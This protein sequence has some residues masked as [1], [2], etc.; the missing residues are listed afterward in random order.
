MEIAVL[1]FCIVRC[2]L[3]HFS[4]F[5]D[6]A[7]SSQCGVSNFV[8]YVGY[9]S[10]SWGF[11]VVEGVD[12]S[13]RSIR[14]MELVQQRRDVAE[15]WHVMRSRRR[16]VSRCRSPAT[17]REDTRD[18]TGEP[19]DRP[20]GQLTE[21]RVTRWQGLRDVHETSS[22]CI[23]HRDVFETSPHIFDVCSEVSRTTEAG[24]IWSE[25]TQ[26]GSWRRQRL[27]VLYT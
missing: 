6:V 12:P 5:S 23:Y 14:P 7:A 19:T 16:P 21:Y 3:L 2:F 4:E 20:T 26:S 11:D 22:R 17:S 10:Y 25:P 8:E 18:W 27:I 24:A 15:P 1:T 13:P 9:T